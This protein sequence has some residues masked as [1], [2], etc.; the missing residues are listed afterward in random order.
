MLPVSLRCKLQV[1]HFVT[2]EAEREAM[3]IRQIQRIAEGGRILVFCSSKKS[4]DSFAR[5]LHREKASM[6]R[7]LTSST[8]GSRAAS[9]A[10]NPS[11]EL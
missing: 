8:S 1:I 5:T 10:P 6:S 9:S 2:K 7:F 3:A 4:V 11:S